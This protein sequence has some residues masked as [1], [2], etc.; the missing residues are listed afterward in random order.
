MG[1]WVLLVVGG[2]GFVGFVDKP[3][4]KKTKM[5]LQ[6]VGGGKKDQNGHFLNAIDFISIS[7]NLREVCGI[8]PILYIK[9]Q[10]ADKAYRLCH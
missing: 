2:S 1:L 6:T 10:K 8:Y 7:P 3:F 9:K 5:A 4:G